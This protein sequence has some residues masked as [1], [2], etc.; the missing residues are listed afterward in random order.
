VVES[1]VEALDE[2]L[3][4]A[5]EPFA[6]VLTGLQTLPAIGPITGAPYVAALGTPERFPDSSHVVSYLGLAVS[7]YDTGER[8]RHGHITKRGAADVRGL[9]CEAAQHVDG[10]CSPQPHGLPFSL[11]WS[12][13]GPLR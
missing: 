3:A 13:G 10:R 8:E 4:R 9:L 5:A 2:E 6:D 12:V 7:T 1:N 11:A